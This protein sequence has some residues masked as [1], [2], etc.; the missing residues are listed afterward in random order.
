MKHIIYTFL[1]LACVSVFN[2]CEKDNKIPPPDVTPS[3]TPP[4]AD[5]KP[6]VANAGP[7]QTITLSACYGVTASAELDGSGSYDVDSNIIN[8][9]WKNLQYPNYPYLYSASHVKAKVEKLMPGNHG[10]ELTVKDIFGLTSKDTVL[11]VVKAT[12]EKHDL[13]LSLNSNYTF[14]ND[15]TICDWDLFCQYTDLT[16]I[17]G[18]INLVNIGEFNWYVTQYADTASSNNT[19]NENYIGLHFVSYNGAGISGYTSVN[20]KELIMKGGGTFTGTFTVNYSSA[21]NCDAAV[22]N[23]L[24]PLTVTG[25]L[26]VVT[27]KVNIRIQGTV[28]F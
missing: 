2:S 15:T 16:N 21:T 4:V 12:P 22:L 6:P 25:T 19:I 5:N 8:Y 3:I 27:K 1:I 24:A 18:S 11:I 28:Y 14:T 13:D 17:T 23:N 7:D 20:F 10:F 26:E 9:S